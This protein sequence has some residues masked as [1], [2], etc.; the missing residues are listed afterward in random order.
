MS[1]SRSWQ[2]GFTLLELL[3]VISIIGILIAMGT[4]AFS[5]AQQSSRDARRQSDIKA[6]QAAFEQ[7]YAVNN[8]TYDDCAVMASPE[9]L[10]AGMPLDPQ[11][12]AQYDCESTNFTYC[13]CADLERDTGGNATASDCNSYGSGGFFCLENLQ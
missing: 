8:G 7:Y 6:M 12:G 2:R 9:Y 5:T 4:A 1:G 10:P 3:V 11:T 13:V